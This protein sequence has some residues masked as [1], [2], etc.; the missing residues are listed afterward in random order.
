MEMRPPMTS[1][2]TSRS[3]V[4]VL[5]LALL[6][7]HAGAICVVFQ[8]K[9]LRANP[10]VAL[11]FHGTVREVQTT[12]AGEIVTFDVLRVWKGQVPRRITVYNHRIGV[13][14][15][16]FARGTSYFIDAYPLGAQARTA[17]GLSASSSPT[18]GT[19]FC[20]AHQADT[21]RARADADNDP[22]QAP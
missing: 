4:V 15:L 8:F 18:Y 2:R 6:Q 7:Q 12:E 19:G 20:N 10:N 5:A 13:E 9:E 11:I 17:F 22:G 3:V 14:W 1:S 21:A 16:S